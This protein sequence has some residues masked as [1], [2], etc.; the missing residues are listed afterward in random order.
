MTLLNKSKIKIC[1]IR[2]I[3]TVDCCIKNN[4]EYFGLIFY[5]K[6]PRNIPIEK[7]KKLAIKTNAEAIL[8]GDINHKIYQY[9]IVIS[10]TGSQL[11]IIGLGLIEKSIKLRKHKP[12]LLI[13]LAVPRDIEAEISE[14]DD[15]FFYTLDNLSEMAQDGIINLSDTPYDILGAIV[16]EIPNAKSANLYQLR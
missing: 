6:S 9:D 15:I 13:D 8:I 14:L 10:C 16:D 11:P 4:I 3:D 2:E 5:K 7:A 1:G 12:M